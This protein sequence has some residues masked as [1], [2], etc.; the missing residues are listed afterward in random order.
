MEFVESRRFAS[1]S[2]ASVPPAAL[3]ALVRDALGAKTRITRIE[4]SGNGD[5]NSNY[6][7]SL[8]KPEQKVF[9]KMENP[10]LLPAFYHG[11]IS[12]ESEGLRLCREHGIPC[13]VQLAVDP[14]GVRTGY[15]FLLTEFIDGP[16]L[17]EA[18]ASMSI[19]QRNDMRRE[20]LDLT[21]RLNAIGVPEFGD[22]LPD[23]NRGRHARYRDAFRRLYEILM[24]DCEN[25]GLLNREQTSLIRE[26]AETAYLRMEDVTSSSFNHMDLHWMNVIADRKENG[27]GIRAL[28][29][30]G[31]AMYGHPGTDHHRL[32]VFCCFTED[33]HN[34][35]VPLRYPLVGAALFGQILLYGLE[36]IVFEGMMQGD[37]GFRAKL[38]EAS[39]RWLKNPEASF[40]G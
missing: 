39:L 19:P 20:V 4:T 13:P 38:T 14:D 10:W 3:A 31:N 24:A 30:F 21:G 15:R 7:I 40:V 36:F 37:W 26:A 32:Y 16:L 18:W 1:T 8:E 12:R 25:A 11:Q 28:L 27:W 17:S 9:L 29:D 34:A 33:F 22:L 2:Q 23:G 6:V 5:V 35:E